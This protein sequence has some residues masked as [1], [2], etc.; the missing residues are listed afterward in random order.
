M[1]KKTKTS[2]QSQWKTLN[3]WLVSAIL[4]RQHVK[5]LKFYKSN[6]SLRKKKKKIEEKQKGKNR[7][8]PLIGSQLPHVARWSFPVN[9]SPNVY[10][11][12]LPFKTQKYIE[13]YFYMD[14]YI[15]RYIYI[16]I[17]IDITK[18]LKIFSFLLLESHSSLQWIYSLRRTCKEKKRYLNTKNIFSHHLSLQQLYWLLTM[19]NLSTNF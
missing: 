18:G 17:Y 6:I 7:K 8:S 5:S 9:I 12:T 14:T 16:E 3:L 4:C 10:K 19:P 11:N 13:I 2:H 1:K 15:Y